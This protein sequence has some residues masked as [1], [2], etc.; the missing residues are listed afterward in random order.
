MVVLDGL[1]VTVGHIMLICCVAAD[2]DIP[3]A[4]FVTTLK[5]YILLSNKPFIVAVATP[6]ATLECVVQIVGSV[7]NLY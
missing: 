6:A 1:V 3:P 5:S 2:V 4:Q 7:D